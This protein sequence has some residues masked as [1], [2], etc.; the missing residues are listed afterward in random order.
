VRFSVWVHDQAV[1][2]ISLPDDEARNLARFVLESV[3]DGARV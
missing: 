3:D 2:A 1:C